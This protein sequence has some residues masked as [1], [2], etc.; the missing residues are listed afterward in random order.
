MDIKNIHIGSHIKKIAQIKELSITRACIFLKCSHKDI[1]NMYEKDTL[2]TKLLLRWSKLLEYNFFMLY[3][4][5]LQIFSPKAASTK[6]LSAKEKD[7]EQYEF[8]K[9]IYS[10][11][12]ILWLLEKIEHGELTTQEIIKKYNIPRTTIYRW[13]K[14]H[15]K[16]K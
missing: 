8:R 4:S 12:I 3:H 16:I 13:K 2:E 10:E 5:H 1:L 11:E 9:N 7:R 6:L 14:R 15:T